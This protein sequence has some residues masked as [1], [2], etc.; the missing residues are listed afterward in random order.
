MSNLLFDGEFKGVKLQGFVGY[1]YSV[2]RA[3]EPTKVIEQSA[4]YRNTSSDTTNDILKYR[5]QHLVKADL[6]VRYKKWH[7]I[8]KDETKKIN[9]QMEQYIM[10]QTLIDVINSILEVNKDNYL[11]KLF[12]GM[13]YNS[14]ITK[15]SDEDITKYYEESI[16]KKIIKCKLKNI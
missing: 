2:S 15:F 7:N 13:F 16:S 12:S 11:Y 4:T 10:I 6:M 3:L 8:E 5:P 14:L 9:E 1:T